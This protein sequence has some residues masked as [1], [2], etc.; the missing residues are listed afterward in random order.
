MS[1]YT[2]NNLNPLL[3]GNG[4]GTLS[5]FGWT[6][7]AGLADISVAAGQQTQAAKGLAQPV[8][9]TAITVTRTATDQTTSPSS[10]SRTR[11]QG[12]VQFVHGPNGNLLGE[13]QWLYTWDAGN[14]LVSAESTLGALARLRLEY[15]YDGLGRRRVKREYAWTTDYWQLATEHFFIWDSWLLIF[16][17]ITDH[18]HA[19]A[20][21]HTRTYVC[22]LDL[23]GQLGGEGMDPMATAG[24]IGGILAVA[25][26]SSAAQ[27]A[28]VAL[29]LYDGNGNVMDLV[30]AGTAAVLAT[31][32]YGPFGNTLVA[33]GPLAELTT[34]SARRTSGKRPA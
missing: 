10:T 31:Y 3:T 15:V 22:G 32:E 25:S 17:R 11:P 33:S 2:Y 29:F 18:T 8:G 13:G 24:G 16:E 27:T 34:T 1:A 21:T 23:S 28:G 4:S 30:D 7:T 26:A 5:A 12:A 14:R 9:D 6:S 19:P 20:V